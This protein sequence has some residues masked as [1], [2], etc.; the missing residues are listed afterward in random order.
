MSS[1]MRIPL[2]LRVASS[3]MHSISSPQTMQEGFSLS[4]MDTAFVNFSSLSAPV[5]IS[6]SSAWELPKAL[7]N[8]V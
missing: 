1:G 5:K 6:L 8:P 7:I 2:A 4:S 3:F